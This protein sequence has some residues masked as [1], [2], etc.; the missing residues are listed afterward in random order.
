[1]LLHLKTLLRLLLLP[2]AGLLMLA[3]A[4]AFL[5]K[6][7]PRLGWACLMLGL[8]SLWLLSTPLISDSLSRV[9]ERYPAID[10][11]GAAAAQAI[12][13]LGGGGQREFAPE[14]GGP[15]ADPELLERVSY[16]AY[17]ARKTGLPVLL[18]GHL[19]EAV[20]MHD[21]LSRNFGIEA[22]WVDDQAYDTFQNASNSAR[23]LG[24]DGVRNIILVTHATH[25]WRAAHEF[26]AA[27][28][29]VI[30]APAGLLGTRKLGIL[31][32]VPSAGA[33][34]RACVAINELLGEQVRELLTASHLRRH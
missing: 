13:V 24:K 19:I 34:S 5:Q 33:L 25:M 7:R 10:L 17:L 18:T 12:V 29:Q 1:M 11:P 27:G 3:M 8:G 2:P 20:A 22:R 14:Y 9:A 32:F 26:S 16:G 30:P 4:G 23:M 6:R 31:S 28:L 15:A 21:T